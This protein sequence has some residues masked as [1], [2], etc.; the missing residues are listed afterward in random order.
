MLQLAVSL[1]LFLE[2]ITLQQ[3]AKRNFAIY[4]VAI[5]GCVCFTIAYAYCFISE[6]VANS[7][8]FVLFIATYAILTVIY[9]AAIITLFSK[10]KKLPI[11][12]ESVA[13]SVNLQFGVFL[14]SYLTRLTF[15]SVALVFCD[16]YTGSLVLILLPIIVDILPLGVVL[17][18]H[19]RSYGPVR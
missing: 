18:A 11:A 15:Y 10:L 2:E 1:Q 9:I 14:V 13:R 6:S 5:I 8:I 4:T 19:H 3:A 17:Y 16:E 12:M 7:S